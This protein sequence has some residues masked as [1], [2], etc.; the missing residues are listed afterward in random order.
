LSSRPTLPQ[1]LSQYLRRGTYKNSNKYP[2]RVINKEWKWTFRSGDGGFLFHR[3]CI[4]ILGG[5]TYKIGTKYTFL[6]MVKSGKNGNKYPFRVRNKEWKWTFGSEDGGFLFRGCC[7]NISGGITYKIS[8][9]YT[10]LKTVKS[11][12]E[13]SG[14]EYRVLELHARDV[15]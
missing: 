11:G 5:I 9:K 7:I 8:T 3:C 10:F 13:G 12:N 2:F 1:R 14:N 4:N 15:V 6:K